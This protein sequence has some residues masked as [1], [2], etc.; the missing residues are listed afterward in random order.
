MPTV[1]GNQALK[2]KLI[3]KIGGLQAAVE[4]AAE[5]GG[6]KGTP[7][8]VDYSRGSFFEDFFGSSDSKAALEERVTRELM[9]RLIERCV[10][11]D[12]RTGL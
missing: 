6:I 10:L 5:Q 9:R 3:D 12:E 4:D 11:N 1:L 7:K 8:V 2:A